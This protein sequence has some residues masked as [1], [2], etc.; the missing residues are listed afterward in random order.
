MGEYLVIAVKVLATGSEIGVE[1]KVMVDTT[2][3]QRSLCSGELPRE[4][5]GELDVT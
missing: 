2:T 5:I 3:G 4:N 1:N